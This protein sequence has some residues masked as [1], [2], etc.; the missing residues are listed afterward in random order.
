ML[1]NLP[2]IERILLT[3][4]MD[5]PF[6]GVQAAGLISEQCFEEVFAKLWVCVEEDWPG[7]EDDVHSV[8]VLFFLLSYVLLQNGWST[9]TVARN[10]CSQQNMGQRE[11]SHGWALLT[12]HEDDD[13]VLVP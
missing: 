11:L 5:T 10:L 3:H 1:R 12:L 2:H 7:W 13:V 6:V 9:Y 4:I 8:H